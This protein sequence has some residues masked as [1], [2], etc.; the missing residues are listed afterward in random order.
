LADGSIT[1]LDG[2]DAPAAA[3]VDLTGV[4]LRRVAAAE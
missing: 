3:V 1:A 2:I 4:V